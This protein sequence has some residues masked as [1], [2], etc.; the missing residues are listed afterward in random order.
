MR[1]YYVGQP[2]P[3]YEFDTRAEFLVL[4]SRGAQLLVIPRDGRP[5]VHYVDPGRS[6]TNRYCVWFPTVDR[7]WFCDTL[8]LWDY[9]LEVGA[10]APTAPLT[11]ATLDTLAAAG[12]KIGHPLDRTV[13][14]SLYAS[15]A[16]S[17]RFT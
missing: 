6:A 4:P 9:L 2:E 17:F 11:D 10:L 1:L 7:P 8:G 3:F 16:D 5:G 12:V 15:A 13:A 14:H